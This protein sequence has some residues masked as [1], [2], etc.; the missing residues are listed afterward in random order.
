MG[1]H[2][3]Y[4]DDEQVMNLYKS[5]GVSQVIDW[6]TRGV[7]ALVTSG[8]L[9]NDITDILYTNELTSE[10]QREEINRKIVSKTLRK[11]YD[12]KEEKTTTSS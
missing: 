12:E 1:F 8:Q 10:E 5:G 7:D 11:G 3:R 2:K 6:F 9:S 4:V